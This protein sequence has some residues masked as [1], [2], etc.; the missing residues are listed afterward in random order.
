MNITCSRTFA[1]N[2]RLAP[3]PVD[4]SSPRKLNA[5]GGYYCSKLHVN[6]NK[7]GN[8]YT[9]K[10]SFKTGDTLKLS[11]KVLAGKVATTADVYVRVV[12]P[13]SSMLYLDALT[14]APNPVASSW[15]VG[16]WGPQVYFTYTFDG[17]EPSGSYKFEIYLTEPGTTTVIGRIN[18][19]EFTF[20]P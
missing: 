16:N 20:T 11:P 10:L 14:P 7:A 8:S 1:H 5:K 6:A 15:T 2:L 19:A 17:T 13:D 18:S 3:S 9:I 12:L 4:D